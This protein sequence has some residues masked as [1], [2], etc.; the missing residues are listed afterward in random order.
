[1]PLCKLPAYAFHLFVT[2]Q[3]Y[4]SK[5]IYNSHVTSLFHSRLRLLWCCSQRNRK[6]TTFPFLLRARAGRVLY[7][8][9]TVYAVT[10]L[11]ICLYLFFDSHWIRMQRNT[12]LTFACTI[13]THGLMVI[14]CIVPQHCSYL[15]Y[16]VNIIIKYFH[17]LCCLHR[18]KEEFFFFPILFFFHQSN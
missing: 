16:T 18:H 1:M 11:C 7:G 3:T 17:Y 14:V 12:F 5:Y 9:R 15:T 2:R 4:Q 13:A 10:I 8:G 6:L